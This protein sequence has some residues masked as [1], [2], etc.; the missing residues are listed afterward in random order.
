MRQPSPLP[1]TLIGNSTKVYLDF[2]FEQW[3]STD[4]AIT[5]EAYAEY[6][7]CFSDPQMIRA[8]CLDYRAIELDLEHDEA[9]RDRKLMCPM[10][11]LWG[12]KMRK[13]PGWQTG[14]S[15]DMMA[16]WR[17]RAVDVR[18]KSLVCG[19]FLPEELPEET[20]VELLTFLSS[21]R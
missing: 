5:E 7:R 11:Q 20:T 1:E 3:C 16:V 8:T 4:G 14:V 18:G 12:S 2:L 13:R 9:D 17:Q 19:H 21:A 15:L 10:L 6:L